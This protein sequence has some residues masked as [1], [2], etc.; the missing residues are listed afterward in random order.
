MQVQPNNNAAAG[1]LEQLQDIHAAAEPSLWPPA[2]GWWVLA[3]IIL[4]VLV[5]AAAH[6]IRK[7]RIRLRRRR[8][9]RELEGLAKA[10]DP[11][12]QPAPYLAAL[13]RFFRGV[14]LKA[15]PESNCVR[16]EGKE[17]V[18]FIRDH[19]PGNDE[20]AGLDILATGPFRPDPDYEPAQLQSYARQWVLKHG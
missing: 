3:A 14:A 1:L 16:L 19:L 8:L 5:F 6:L 10:F 4:A 18:A 20:S 15:F 7:L 2:P 17:W 12:V 11:Q 9:L 13:S